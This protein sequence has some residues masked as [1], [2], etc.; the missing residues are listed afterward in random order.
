MNSPVIFSRCRV[1]FR[2]CIVGMVMIVGLPFSVA[3]AVTLAETDRVVTAGPLL[4]L[5]AGE[6]VEQA[7]PRMQRA[8]S[9]ARKRIKRDSTQWKREDRQSTAEQTS[10]QL[11]GEKRP[12][13]I[14]LTTREE[15]PEYLQTAIMSYVYEGSSKGESPQ[16]EGQK[17]QAS[18]F[19][20]LRVDLVGVIHIADRSYYEE[21]NRVLKKYDVVLYELVAPEGTRVIPGQRPAHPVTAIQQFLT[22]TL[23]LSYQLDVIDYH[24]RNFVH[25]DL[26]PEQFYQSMQERG[27][28]TWAMFL[29]AFGYEW[30][31][32]MTQQKSTNDADLF[33]A[34]W[35]KNRQLELK[36]LFAKEMSEDV[37]GQIRA[38]EG[39][40]GSTLIAGR[41]ERV[42]QVLEDQA[43]KG[44]K[45]IAIFY[46][47][48]HMPHFHDRLKQLGFVVEK[49]R[50]LNAW[51]LRASSVS[52]ASKGS[53]D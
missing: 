34:L 22:R 53:V 36:R 21:L 4:S 52:A 37:E 28:S 11:Q 20:D 39:P 5:Y 24:G 32:S 10:S 35:S 44:A 41:N 3:S 17:Q 14:R 12:Q 48:G 31:R 45:T 38:L 8:F 40:Q 33:R 43:K 7:T 13:F 46:G 27:E 9:A 50:W 42:L 26:S 47:A 6:S 23:G 29:R 49:T 51:D 30:A 25:A 16:S 18:W 19:K 2:G 1:V 15:E